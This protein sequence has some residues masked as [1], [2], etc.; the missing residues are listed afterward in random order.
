MY[1]GSYTEVL[2]TAMDIASGGNGVLSAGVLFQ[3]LLQKCPENFNHLLGRECVLPPIDEVTP[4]LGANRVKLG[5]TA[6]RILSPFGGYLSEVRSGVRPDF[7]VD[8]KQ[9]AAAMLWDPVPEVRLFL[10]FNGVSDGPELRTILNNLLREADAERH[11][12]QM[13][14]QR[15]GRLRKLRVIRERLLACCYGQDEVVESIITQLGIFWN[16]P[17]DKRKGRG[18]ALCLVGS[19]GTGKTLLLNNLQRILKEELDIPETEVLD[20]NR[21]TPPQMAIELVGRDTMWKD[22]GR[23]G[24]LTKRAFDTPRSLIVLENI[25]KA[26]QDALSYVNSMVTNGILLDEFTAEKVSFADN[27]IIMTTSLDFRKNGN[28]ARLNE[29]RAGGIPQDKMADLVCD[30]LHTTS[31]SVMAERNIASTLRVI[32]S[33]VDC[34]IPMNE[35]DVASTMKMIE[36]SIEENTVSVARSYDVEMEYDVPRL[37][38]LFLDSLENLSSA[39]AI[40]PMVTEALCERTLQYF[41]NR[42]DELPVDKL[43]IVVDDLPELPGS[44]LKDEPYSMEWIVNHTVAR[45]KNARR[46]LYDVEFA[47][48]EKVLELHFTNLRYIALPCI[49]EAEF[50]SVTV[51]DVREDELVG[52]SKPFEIARAALAHIQSGTNTGTTPQYG[53]LL[54][55]PPGTGKTSFAKALAREL[56]MPFIYLSAADLCRNHPAESV[57]R[58]QQVFAAAHR[59]G[60]IIFFDEIDALGS[61][62]ESS[63]VHSVVINTVLTELDGFNDRHVLVIGATNRPECLD[64]AL[65]RNGRLH[66]RIYLGCLRDQGDRRRLIELCAEKAGMR[67]GAD[68]LDFAVSCTYNWSPANIKSLLD[69]A[70]RK[71]AINKQAVSRRD[72]A[73]AMHTE[74]FGEET[75]KDT[76]SAEVERSVALHESGHALACSLLGRSWVQVSINSGGS[77]MGYLVRN[78]EKHRSRT[79]DDLRR[80]IMISLAGRAAEETLGL[81][82]V[83]SSSDFMYAHDVAACLVDERMDAKTA[84]PGKALT[85]HMRD[86]AIERVINECM[87]EVRRLMNKNRVAL[88]SLVE[89]LLERRVLLQAEAEELIA[90][91]CPLI[92]VNAKLQTR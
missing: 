42:S 38:V 64:P 65:T 55:G 43:R 62:N 61:R 86:A 46:L 18:L 32:L 13:R 87:T 1:D 56:K 30:M 33:K 19:S 80:D 44:E 21:F 15:A 85:N 5:A 63:G 3:A 37:A 91:V 12:E 78:M 25:D 23:E 72:I 36:N 34:I 49:E 10:Q 76:L 84:F 16:S 29:N 90:P 2:N 69:L 70:F 31:G 58:V 28:F 71:A 45:R 57:K 52:M 54:Y 81:P 66:T 88:E 4:T 35:H 14:N 51:P 20:M 60:A 74:N 17:V 11:A 73:D 8:A 82:T 7:P 59:L 83:G 26:H 68:V 77:T 53:L 50:F 39:N 67:F 6:S 9:I 89:A 41:I 48:E 47:Y 27:I 24:E 92:S 75:Q 79:A 40:N 22:G